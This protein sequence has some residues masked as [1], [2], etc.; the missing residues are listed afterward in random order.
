M[1][2]KDEVRSQNAEVRM[3]ELKTQNEIRMPESE[4]RKRNAGTGRHRAGYYF[5]ASAF[6]ILTPDFIFIPDLPK[7][8]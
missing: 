3:Q 2:S 7:A 5:P 8:W 6:C 1:G 4:G